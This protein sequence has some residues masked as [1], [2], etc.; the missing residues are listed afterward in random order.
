[1]GGGGVGVLFE[2]VLLP[3]TA[4]EHRCHPVAPLCASLP[5]VRK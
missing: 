5:R 2:L 3:G 1:V 4:M